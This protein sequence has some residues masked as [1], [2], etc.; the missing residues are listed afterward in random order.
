VHGGRWRSNNGVC[1]W[2]GISLLELNKEKS[3]FR[4]AVPSCASTDA[5]DIARGFLDLKNLKGV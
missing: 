5:R 1:L 3:V 2:K 4:T